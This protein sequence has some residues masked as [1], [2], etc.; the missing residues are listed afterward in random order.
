MLNLLLQFTQDFTVTCTGEKFIE[1]YSDQKNNLNRNE[2]WWVLEDI[3]K[4]WLEGL[5]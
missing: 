3:I 5:W 1:Q 4:I 2:T